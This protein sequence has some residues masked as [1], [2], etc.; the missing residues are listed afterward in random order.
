MS[1]RSIII[2]IFI[3]ILCII[4]IIRSELLYDNL[5]RYFLIN[6]LPSLKN[7]NIYLYENFNNIFKNI[8]NINSTNFKDEFKFEL[9]KT[10]SFPKQ[11]A[12]FNF[13]KFLIVLLFIIKTNIF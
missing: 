11:D 5:K 9:K 8:K 12:F 1:K 10:I 6:Q 4:I 3:I 2:I 13:E 7:N